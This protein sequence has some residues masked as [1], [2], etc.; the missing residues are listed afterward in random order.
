[1]APAAYPVLTLPFDIISQI[2]VY[3]L[4]PED[5]AS[6]LR[7]DAPLLLAGICRDWRDISL[8]T[9]ELWNTTH[10]T[11]RP[12]SLLKVG[13]L[14]EF[15]IPRAGNLPLQLSLVYKSSDGSSASESAGLDA[16]SEL[17]AQYARH[18]KTIELVMSFSA[19]FRLPCPKEAF[20][21]LKKVVLNCE[22]GWAGTQGV[23][24]FTNSP[25]LKELHII[26]GVRALRLALPWEQLATLRLET[27]SAAECLKVLA[28]APNLAAVTATVWTVDV[29]NLV[30]ISPLPHLESLCLTLSHTRGPALLKALTLPA[31]QHLELDINASEEITNF[32]S[33]ITRSPVFLRRLSVR[34]G[35][36][37]PTDYFMQLFSVLDSLEELEVRKASAA[38]DTGLLL[39]KAQRLLLPNLKSLRIE[40]TWS[41][42]EDA[43]LL[44]DF[45]ESR[46]R[47]PAKVVLPVRLESFWLSSP[48]TTPP[49]LR[50]PAVIRLA[51]L[52]AEGMSIQISSSGYSW[53]TGRPD[54]FRTYIL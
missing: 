51:R 53:F 37:W 34:L 1:M 42:G 35:P 23:Q 31:L 44:A 7:T 22:S 54:A 28:L 15:W 2:F 12:H 47:V 38:L 36:R 20:T 9:H 40:R 29:P 10:L 32:A 3:C 43:E 21:S 19:L 50:S 46:W 25:N 33:L 27:T 4:P 18:W 48:L 39:L 41:D 14:L 49:E 11:L 24:L 8:A 13:P 30:P 52:R 16:L 5:D 26:P 6:P 45:L 17:I